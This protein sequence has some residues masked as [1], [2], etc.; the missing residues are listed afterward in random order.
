[1][2]KASI[3]GIILCRRGV[4]SADSSQAAGFVF[5]LYPLSGNETGDSS[6]LG[7]S[8]ERIS[9]IIS[10]L[11]LTGQYEFE[12]RKIYVIQDP[13]GRKVELSEDN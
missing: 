6:R 8:V 2:A 1:M 11:P 9:H 10:G 3:G 5:E 13:D 7:F 12:G 4:Y